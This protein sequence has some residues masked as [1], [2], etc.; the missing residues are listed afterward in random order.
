MKKIVKTDAQWKHL[1]TPEQYKV[2][3]RK[4][5]EPAFC[6][7]LH[8]HKEPGFY[9]CVC[10]SLPL[11]SSD[12]KFDSG[13]GWPSFFAPAAEENIARCEDRSLGMVRTEVLCAKCDAHLGHVFEDGPEPSGLR[14][15][16]NSASLVF[17]PVSNAKWEKATFAAGCFWGVESAFRRVQGVKNATVGY[18]GG[19][20]EN[21]TYED[22]CSGTTG[23]AEAVLVEF[24][25]AE[26][27]YDQLLDVLWNCHNPTTPNRQGP[28]IGSQYRS[29]IFCHTPRQ[30]EAALASKKKL[31]Q[32]GKF[33]DPIVTEIVPAATFYRAEEYHQK[34]L[35]KRGEASCPR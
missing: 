4:G 22:V 1:L 33:R 11:F 35:Q 32:S 14:F 7:N 23:H 3:R 13:T 15:C 9:I 6:G 16:L 10:C 28:D 34:Y 20:F 26:V 29:V 27:S 5:T 31:D 30:K 21:P 2:A 24:D 25:P 12:A 17:I 19:K 18:T 8:D